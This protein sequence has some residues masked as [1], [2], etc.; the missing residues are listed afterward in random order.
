MIGTL[1]K[2][3]VCYLLS[4][5]GLKL[6]LGSEEEEQNID[7]DDGTWVYIESGTVR[8]FVL[9]SKLLTGEEAQNIAAV[10]YTHLSL[11]LGDLKEK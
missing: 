3:G 9:K 5:D 6:H 11:K 10:S 8:G 1:D 4:N 2:D 7:T